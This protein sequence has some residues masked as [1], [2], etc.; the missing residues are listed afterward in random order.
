MTA[1]LW[2]A[3][4][5]LIQVFAMAFQSKSIN[6]GHYALAACG[7]IFIGLSQAFVWKAITTVG[8]GLTET[9]VYAISGG[10]GCV[11]AM[12]T[13]RKFVKDKRG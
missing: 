1:L 4:V 3:L 7:S 2:L 6:G 9:L 13:H 11:C 10:A 8:A 5:S 12:W